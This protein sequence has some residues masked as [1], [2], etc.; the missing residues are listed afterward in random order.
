MIQR[1]SEKTIWK[2]DFELKLLQRVR[3]WIEKDTTRQ[4]LKLKI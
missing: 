3:S 4:I 1:E 2:V